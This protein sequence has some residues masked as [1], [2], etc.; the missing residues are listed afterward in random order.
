ML[1]SYTFVPHSMDKM[2]TYIDYI[3][4]EVWCKAQGRDYDIDVL[5]AGCDELRQVITELHTS[6]LK[7]ADFF[8]TGLQQIFEDFQ[9]LSSDDIE[10]LKQWYHD[11]NSIELLCSNDPAVTPATYQVIDALSVSLSRHFKGFFGNLYS[12]GFLSLASIASHVG[13]MDHHYQAFM[14]ANSRGKC[15]FCGISDVKGIYH[16][17]REA[18]DH[19]LPK[20]KYPFNSIN[21]RN[22]VPA[23]HGCN[24]SYKLVKDPAMHATGKRRK[25]FYPYTNQPHEIE[26]H[27][28]V[29]PQDW[30]HI[31]PEDIDITLG[32]RH[33]REQIDTWLDVYGIEERY[34]AKCCGENDGQSWIQQVCDEWKE[35]GRTPEDFLHTLAR[36]TKRRPYAEANF[37]KK[38][39]LEGCQRA[40]L[41]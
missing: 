28:N 31:Q 11:N 9:G 33:L 23:C 1:F 19:Y 36:H 41:F 22:L 34:Q 18:Y 13:T 35:D 15:P 10:Q 38:A 3:F 8:L 20:A 4:N 21:F 25:A 37:L 16:T 5:F 24:S 26:L 17:K 14:Q 40:G 29:G 27:I 39:F 12:H 30:N 2:Q 6:E 32:P 7:G